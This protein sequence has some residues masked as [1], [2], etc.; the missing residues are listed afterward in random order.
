MTTELSAADEW[1][2]LVERTLRGRGLSELVTSTRDG[3]EVQPLQVNDVPRPA[4]VQAAA[5]SQRARVGWDIRQHHRINLTGSSDRKAAA[6]IEAS[7]ARI[8]DDLAGGV[9]SLELDCSAW[10]TTHPSQSGSSP[11]FGSGSDDGYA[12]LGEVLNRVDL[13]TTP[14]ALAPHAE[15]ALA[16]WLVDLARQTGSGLAPGSSLGL[17]PLGEWSRSGRLLD[18]AAAAEFVVGL[19]CGVRAFA[20]DGTRYADSGASEAQILAW[21]TATGIA[22]LRAL[23]EAGL[24]VAEAASLIGFRLPV[25][26]DQFAAIAMLRAARVMWARV[27]TASGASQSEARQ[28]QHAVT[29]AHIYSRNEPTVNLLRGCAAALAAG[30]GGAD[31]VTVL[32]FEHD[33]GDATVVL[34]SDSSL[35]RRLARNTQHLLMQESHLVRVADPAGGSFHVESL[36]EELAQRAWHLMQQVEV[37]GGIAAVMADGSITSAVERQWQTRLTE[38]STRRERLIGVSDFAVLDDEPRAHAGNSNTVPEPSGLPVRRLAEPFES[39]RGVSDRH[40]LRTGVRPSVWIVALGPEAAH[41]PRTAWTRNLLAAGGIAADRGDS[42]ESPI[43]A[44]SAFSASGRP[45]A[46]ITGTDAI[47]SERATATARALAAEGAKFIALACD[48]S[49]PDDHRAELRSAGVDD[50][51][52]EGIN[53]VDAIQRVHDVLQAT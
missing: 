49:L 14:V 9:T 35:A 52:H 31:A 17:D 16:G 27:V 48:P 44:A 45:A 4:A 36:T 24:L 7:R 15:A 13:I 3:I 47:Y 5:D 20:V 38:L 18:P 22:Y 42:V 19:G 32:P 23:T 37:A 29:A 25:T 1:M 8:D 53:V 46:V 41:A 50:F 34:E 43:A 11:G 51:W 30:V 26:A 2:T 10:L 39:L 40:A 33:S 6:R 28:Y 12:A 21:S